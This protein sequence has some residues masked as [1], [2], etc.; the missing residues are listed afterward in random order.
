VHGMPTDSYKGASFDNLSN[1]QCIFDSD[2]AKCEN[3]SS[4]NLECVKVWGPKTE[5][6]LNAVAARITESV[7]PTVSLIRD[8]NLSCQENSRLRRIYQYT[9]EYPD[10]PPSIIL[11]HLW[12]ICSST[13]DDEALLYSI[14]AWRAGEDKAPVTEIQQYTSRFQNRLRETIQQDSVVELHLFAI[15]FAVLGA[16]GQRDPNSQRVH[17][18]GMTAILHHL[19]SS[20][21]QHEFRL[22]ISASFRRLVHSRLGV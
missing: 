12:N 1:I 9:I 16:R 11:Q 19:N 2:E 21:C 18:N 3:C 4:K 10:F 5:T 22:E 13:F 15:I 14:L 20:R 7:P 6:W 17:L 8:I